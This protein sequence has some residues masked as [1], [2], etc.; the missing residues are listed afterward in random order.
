MRQTK[1]DGIMLLGWKGMC[2]PPPTLARVG[3]GIRCATQRE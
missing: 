2:D 3:K 1:L